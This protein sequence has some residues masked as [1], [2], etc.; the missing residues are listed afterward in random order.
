MAGLYRILRRIRNSYK[1]KLPK[2][3]KIHLV[4]SL[5]KLQ[6]ASNNPLLGQR[7]KPPPTIRITNDKEQE[8]E[9]ILAIQKTRK[10]LSYR[11]KWVSYNKDPEQYPAS[12]F[13][14]APHKLQDF[15]L[16]NPDRLGPLKLL[17][18]Q[19]KMWEDKA[20]SYNELE[21]DTQMP[22]SLRASFF[23]RGG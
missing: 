21:D 6:K 8:V 15:H 13:K 9:E 3:M 14:Y 19:I 4:F 5:D 22:R 1:V 11:A 16:Q 10:Y 20:N 18:N 17:R 12:D 23:T 2:L 7:N